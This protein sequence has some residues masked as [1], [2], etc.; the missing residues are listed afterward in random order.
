MEVLVDDAT[1]AA[2][3]LPMSFAPGTEP[4]EVQFSADGNFFS[5]YGELPA[6]YAAI[7]DP[8]GDRLAQTY[9]QSFGTRRPC[10]RRAITA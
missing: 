1:V 4:G 6:L 3:T 7:V 9:L 2:R 5:Q 8:A 10:C